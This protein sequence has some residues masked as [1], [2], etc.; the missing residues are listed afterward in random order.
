MLFLGKTV[1]SVQKE[2]FQKVMGRAMVPR[3]DI[4]RPLYSNK[5]CFM[6]GPKIE[7]RSL[8]YVLEMTGQQGAISINQK[9]I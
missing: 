4:W 8:Y 3:N 2:S 7:H 1:L 6:H 9:C 5:T